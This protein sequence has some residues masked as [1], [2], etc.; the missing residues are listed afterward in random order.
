[1]LLCAMTKTQTI[2][3]AKWTNP[4]TGEDRIYIN[5]DLLSYGDKAFFTGTGHGIQLKTD[6]QW[7]REEMEWGIV[8]QLEAAFPGINVFNF[9][10]VA[11]FAS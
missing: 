10:S 9:D 5:S 2:K 11:S 6:R 1:M 4:R 3:L 7:H 8:E